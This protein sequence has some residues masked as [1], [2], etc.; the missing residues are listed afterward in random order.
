MRKGKIDL[1]E[2][3][4]VAATRLVGDSKPKTPAGQFKRNED[5]IL[6]RAGWIAG[7]RARGRARA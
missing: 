7:Y 6:F 2:R 5:I 4:T 3:G 1:W